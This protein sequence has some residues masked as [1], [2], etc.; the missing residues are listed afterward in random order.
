VNTDSNPPQSAT[1]FPLA[2]LA[3]CIGM[4][5]VWVAARAEVC[6]LNQILPYTPLIPCIGIVLVI[7]SCEWLWPKLREA[8]SGALSRKALRPLDLRRAAVRICGV[9]ATLSVVALAYW[10]FPEYSGNFYDPYWRFLRSMAPVLLVVPFY[11]LWADT[12]LMDPHDEYYAFGSLVIGRWGAADWTQIRRLFLGWAVKGFFLPLMTVYLAGEFQSLRGAMGDAGSNHAL[13][14]VYQVF[15]HLS[16]TVDLLFCVVGYGAAIRLFDSEIRSVEPTVAGWVIALMCYQPFYSVIGRFYL[17]YDD[18]LYWDNWLQNWPAVR[19]G[20]AALIIALT[21]IYALCT[22]SFGLRFS[23]LTH[24]GI[25]TGG[26]YRF[27]KHPAYLSKNLSWWLISVPFIS[28]QG[29]SAALRNCLLLGLLNVI[30]YARARTEERHLSRDPKYVAYAL[31]I[32]EHGLLRHLAMAL[33][34]TRY[35]PPRHD[36]RNQYTSR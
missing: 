5:L 18:G 13:M 23:N 22:V 17:Q 1:N 21:V 14:P 31:W 12:R 29:W 2:L 15:Y 16:Y 7:A 10:L 6:G 8:S 26:P 4:A 30:Y 35:K 33:P 9:F 25:I 20:W 34:F 28:G 36:D 19:V 3:M 32:S 27:T 24:R 11:L